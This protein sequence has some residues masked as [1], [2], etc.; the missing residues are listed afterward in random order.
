ML[1]R[2]IYRK[3][4]GSNLAPAATHTHERTNF[5][6]HQ[7]EPR[8]FFLS[9]VSAVMSESA[10]S[11][12]AA[13]SQVLSPASSPPPDVPAL[14]ETPAK[15]GSMTSTPGKRKKSKKKY[16]SDSKLEAAVNISSGTDS[17]HDKE[18]EVLDVM[19]ESDGWGAVSG[20]SAVSSAGEYSVSDSASDASEGSERRRKFKRARVS[21]GGGKGGKP[22]S[23]YTKGWEG[24]VGVT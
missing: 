3:I 15:K 13:A 23:H 2:P 22:L 12:A 14:S 16:L 8:V 19:L 18:Y 21:G 4:C 24:K 9:L 17:E 5:L 1:C 10:S 7:E 20:I 6:P 11:R